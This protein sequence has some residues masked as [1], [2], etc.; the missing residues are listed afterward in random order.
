[1]N[2]K[3]QHAK[4]GVI[5]M[6]VILVTILVIGMLFAMPL[7]RVWQKG[8]QGKSELKQAEWNRQIA[9]EEAK[10]ELESA[11]L[12]KQ[13]DIIRA[14]GVAEANKI[15]AE[16][17]SAQYI[18]WRW[19]EGLHDGSSEVIYVPT[20]ANLPILEATRNLGD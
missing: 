11:K 10:A 20:E 9:I 18:Q 15:I 2:K 3:A 12:K 17:L 4:P 6:A 8:Q 16:S 13:A 5:I 19:V 7:Y 1:M 14:E